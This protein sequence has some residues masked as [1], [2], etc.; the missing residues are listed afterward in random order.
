ML[1]SFWDAWQQNADMNGGTL[2][3]HCVYVWRSS[4]QRGTM[5]FQCL[6]YYRP[7]FILVHNLLLF[8]PWEL[9]SWSYRRYAASVLEL[10]YL[11]TAECAQLSPAGDCRGRRQNTLTSLAVPRQVAGGLARYCLR[12]S[13]GRNRPPVRI[14]HLWDGLRI[15]LEPRCWAR[16]VLPGCCAKYG[17]SWKVSRA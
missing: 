6:Q 9:A 10:L 1:R 12:G 8:S 4:H 15:V 14:L 5:A 2:R 7:L 3:C 17:N 13:V 11:F 16:G